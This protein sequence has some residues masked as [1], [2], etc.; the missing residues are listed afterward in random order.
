MREGAETYTECCYQPSF[1]MLNTVTLK[2]RGYMEDGAVCSPDE[3]VKIASRPVKI[4]SFYLYISS[5]RSRQANTRCKYII[6]FRTGT[7]SI[8]SPLSSANKL[9]VS[10]GNQ[11]D[12]NN[13]A[14]CTLKHRSS[15]R[16]S[17]LSG[18]SRDGKKYDSL[19]QV[20]CTCALSSAQYQGR[21]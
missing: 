8:W 13:A 18:F 3:P 4:C 6:S 16:V 9:G 21:V 11:Y 20:S 2:V 12:G 19:F 7:N 5:V 17:M 1:M 10:N 14:L 15:R